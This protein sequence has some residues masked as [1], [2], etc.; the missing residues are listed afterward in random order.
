M[1]SSGISDVLPSECVVWTT[2]E[3]AG[4]RFLAIWDTGASKSVISQRVVDALS[5]KPMGYTMVQGVNGPPQEREQFLVSF[6]LPNQLRIVGLAVTLGEMGK[7]G[8]DNLD[9]LIG[10]DVIGLGD[11]AVTNFRGQTMF[12]FRYPSK[13]HLD[14][15]AEDRRATPIKG[16]IPRG[17]PK[18]RKKK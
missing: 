11:F 1:S 16:V 13:K 3:D 5:L 4:V 6:G 18:R 10:M 12:S 15:A 9:V 17:K 8:D 2:A 14:F 7:V